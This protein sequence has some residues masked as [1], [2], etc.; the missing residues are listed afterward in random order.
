MVADATSADAVATLEQ[1]SD[2]MQQD[3]ETIMV[4]IEEPAATYDIM[5]ETPAPYTVESEQIVDELYQKDVT[6]T[7]ESAFHYTN[8]ASYSSIPEDLVGRGTEFQLFWMV[9]GIK[10]DVT[11]DA[12]FAVTLVDSDGNGISDQMNWIVPQL[13][14]QQFVIEGVIVTTKAEHLDAGK[15]YI[16]D[17]YPQT[18]ALDGLWTEEIQSGHYIRVTFEE[19]LNNMNDIT[20]FAKS[21]SENASIEVYEKDADTLLTT[22]EGI[23][24]A[25]LY[26]VYLTNL[27]GS[28]DTFDLRI[29]EGTVEFDLIID[30]IFLSP[31][32][33]PVGTTVTVTSGAGPFTGGSTLTVKFDTTTVTTCSANNGGNI[34][35]TC[36]FTVPTASAGAHTVTVTDPG[37]AH[38][39]T[40]TF[41]VTAPVV[42]SVS[43]PSANGAYS[44]GTTIPVTVTFSAPVTVT[45]TPKLLL[46]TGS[47]DREALYAS[48]SGSVLT[49]DYLVQSGDT[50]ADL[51]YVATSSLTLNGG[52]IRD[53]GNN[54]A[55]LT[56]PAPGAAGSL[57]AN[58]NIRI[59][60]TAPTVTLTSAAPNPTNTSPIPV[61]ATFSEVVTGFTL[62]DVIVGNGVAGVFSGSGTTYA[63]SITPSGQGTVTVDVGA[64]AAVDQAVNGNTAA[65]QLARTFD[66][67][68]PALTLST[69]ALNP[70]NSAFSVTANFS[71]SVSG[72]VAGDISVTNGAASGF[73]GSGSVYT[74]AVT[75]SAQGLV[76]VNVNAGVAQDAAGNGNS[77]AAPL[78]RTFDSIAPDTVI[79]SSPADPSFDTSAT[80]TFHSTESPS[81]FECKLDLASFD[82]CSSPQTYSGLTAG[83]HT[84]QVRAADQASN[85]DASPASFTWVVI[86]NTAP[87]V[88]N[89]AYSTSEDLTLN[90]VAPGVLGN[91]TDAQNDALAAIL[92]SGPLHGLLTLNSNGSF[93]YSP[94]ADYDGADS[95]TYKASDGS[96]DSNTATVTLTITAVNDAPVASDDGYGT[97]E[98]TPL[99]ISGPGV[100]AN[101][102]DVDSSTL[103]AIKVTDPLHG[104][105][106]LSTDGGFIYTPNSD[107]F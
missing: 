9:D 98:D 48:G 83:S 22:F 53:S 27:A 87:V 30:P 45:G 104:G 85:T 95:F 36:S 64:G 4:A 21:G 88:V 2:I 3:A 44:A 1:V 75:P 7:H 17:V 102:T 5:Y 43:S 16:E 79:D 24:A 28:Q 57:G 6:V 19:Q 42:T 100:L 103:E 81:T 37:P 23:G 101:D 70:T 65:A 80:F 39:L 78:S 11:N 13:S 93:S 74:F 12:R 54:N 66:S 15:N 38:T 50:S 82:S 10:T 41:T 89:D 33:G 35:G 94:V 31:I 60:T 67:V 86:L 71:E 77:A 14:E 18:M 58:K 68:S 29:S 106:S 61:T 92:V 55:V 51:D 26:Q 63:F 69:L 59:D 91:D 90:V 52:L 105:L 20:V 84:F 73:S 96:L 25:G 72:F 46:E 76:N 56:L 99:T 49:F 40:A 62:S 8:V 97:T 34:Q 32:S 107:F 47:V